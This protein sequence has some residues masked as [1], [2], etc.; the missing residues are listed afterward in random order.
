MKVRSEVRLKVRLELRSE[1]K[2]D[3]L[4]KDNPDSGL[5]A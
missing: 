4:S 3:I 5:C 2:I 1:V